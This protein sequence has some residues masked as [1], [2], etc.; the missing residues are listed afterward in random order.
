MK[1]RGCMKLEDVLRSNIK[2]SLLLLLLNVSSLT[3][4]NYGDCLNVQSYRGVRKIRNGHK[5][6]AKGDKYDDDG[7]KCTLCFNGHALNRVCYQEHGWIDRVVNKP[8]KS[9]H[10]IC[11]PEDGY[12]YHKGESQEC[13]EETCTAENCQ[14]PDCFCHGDSPHIDQSERPMFVVITYDDGVYEVN[15]DTQLRPFYVDNEYEIYN[16]NGCGI[17]TTLFVSMDYTQSDKVKAMYDAG[18]EIAGHTADHGLPSGEDEEDYK[19]TID[20]IDGM[21]R[22][23]LEETGDSRLV[24]SILGFRAPYLRVAHEQQFKALRDL[25][26]VYE[27][28]L[29]S[30]RLAR[31]GRPLWPYT[32]DYKANKCDSAYCN[33]YCYKGFWEIPLNVWKCSNGYYSAMLDYCCVGQNSSTA[34]VDDW[35]DYFLHNFELSYDSKTPLSFYTH[36]HVFD[37][38]PNAF[39]AFIRWLQHISRSYKD[40]WFVTMQQLLRWMKDPLTHKQMLKKWQ[41]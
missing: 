16:P 8:G 38:Y 1:S 40:V 33:H 20:A 26:F 32:L 34:T 28:S 19:D 36:T 3:A 12:P 15:F 6:C 13:P 24:N 25:G 17:K 27:T 7:R 29:I 5:V 11:Y 18:N 2:L 10:T 21:K 39:P 9:K 31:E 35:F 4:A 23:L 41:W 22:I 30:R 14:L 37:F